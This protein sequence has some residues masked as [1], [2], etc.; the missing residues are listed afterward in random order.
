MA[1]NGT[2]ASL[3]GLLALP[4]SSVP[5]RYSLIAIPFDAPSVLPL[6]G[7]IMQINGLNNKRI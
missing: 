7:N 4:P 1:V 5:N 2:V 3:I 6:S